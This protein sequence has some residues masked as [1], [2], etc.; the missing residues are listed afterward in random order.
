MSANEA[1]PEDRA[2]ID[3]VVDG[4]TAVLLVG[5]EETE[6]T[7][8]VAALPEGATEGVW[9]AVR[10]DADRVTVLEVDEEL[11]RHRSEVIDQQMERIRQRHSGG[12]FPRR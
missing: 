10:V 12:R 3:R 7:V 9:V 4:A 8:P 1:I 6:T 11:T 2:V 5:P